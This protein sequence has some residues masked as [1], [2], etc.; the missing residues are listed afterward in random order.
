MLF[1]LKGK[2]RRVVQVVYAS[3]AVLMGVGLIGWGIGGDVSGGLVDAFTGGG[4]AGG[5][6]DSLIQRRVDAAQARLKRNP[7]DARALA[8]LA[9]A[10]FQLA[11]Q[12]ADPNTSVYREGAKDNLARA[13]SAW[14][15]YLRAGVAR[16]DP[17]LAAVMV[18][19]YDPAALNRP[20]KA[21]EAA[22]IVAEARPTAN[23]YLQ[24]ARYATLAKLTRKAELAG[25]RA[26]EL[27]PKAQRKTVEAQLAQ[28]K[29]QA[30]QPAPAG[31]GAGGAGGA[32]G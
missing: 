30:A 9:R 15:R 7:R 14:E 24:L 21:A 31:G 3:L 8:D 29:A 22:E 16:P 1:D 20:A 25:Q 23:A 32:G 28:F 2:R 27:A 5:G 17:S 4:G 12:D 18:Q 10:E 19:V 26:V 6:G 11:G 13:A